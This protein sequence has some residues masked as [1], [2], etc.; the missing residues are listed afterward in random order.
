MGE[1]TKANH[2]MGSLEEYDAPLISGS[3]AMILIGRITFRSS[4]HHDEGLPCEVGDVGVLYTKDTRAHVGYL[5][6]KMAKI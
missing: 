4:D 3:V 6:Y 2:I 1:Q 5:F